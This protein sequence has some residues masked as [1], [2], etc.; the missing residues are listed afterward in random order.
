MAMNKAE[1]A[2][3]EKAKT[4]AALRWTAPVAFDVPV[5]GH[6]EPPATGWAFND[7]AMSVEQGWSCR[8]Y[9]GRGTAPASR[10]SGSQGSRRMFSSRLRALQA[11]RHELEKQAADKLRRID[12]MIEQELA[13]SA[14]A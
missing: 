5:P 13:A 4:V 6:G 1:K 3:L 7:Y 10:M 2:E 8:L 14:E 9:H 12:Q 11:M